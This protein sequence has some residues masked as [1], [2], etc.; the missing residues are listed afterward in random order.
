MFEST[1]IFLGEHRE[2]LLSAAAGTPATKIT[3]RKLQRHGARFP[4][5]GATQRILAAL[6]KLQSVKQYKDPRLN[7]LKTFSYDLGANDLVQYGADQCVIHLMSRHLGSRFFCRSSEAGSEAF[8]RYKRLVSDDSLPFIR[9]DIS[10]RDID[11][12][13]NWTAGKC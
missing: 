3:F 4:T 9:S 12:A 6:E 13:T 2:F 1:L 8:R 10:Q 7:F 5:S 11:S